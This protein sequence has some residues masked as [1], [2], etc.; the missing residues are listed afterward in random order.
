MVV[1][2]ST[3][4]RISVLLMQIGISDMKHVS[5]I[6]LMCSALF[7]FTVACKKNDK[8]ETREALRVETAVAGTSS[9]SAGRSYSG[10]IEESSGTVLSFKVP[11]TISN[12]LVDAGSRVA[13]GQLIAVLD[14]S[15]LRSNYEMAKATLATA[16]DTYNRMKQLHDA[17][18]I[19]DMKWVE[20]ENALK[21]AQSA[22]NIAKNTLNDTKIFAPFSGVIS[23]KFADAG[24]TAAPA[25]PVVKLVEISP[26]KAKISVPEKDISDFAIGAPGVVVVEAADGLTVDGKISDKGVAADPLSRTYDVKFL[27][28][29]PD[30]KLLPGMLCNVSLKADD[31]VEALVVPINSV[32]LDDKNQSFLWTVNEGKA[33]KT[34]IRLGAYTDNGVIVESGLSD[35]VKY[36]VSGQQKVSEGMKVTSVNM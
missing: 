4:L 8:E 11:G 16:Q 33:H 32:L 7:F 36:I 17:N 21:T 2:A 27:I 18:S 12:I 28:S 30:G 19:T 13:K 22:C 5:A 26:L 23:E 14:D 29:N 6:S 3:F 31:A 25:V 10:V 15:S 9:V 35:G 24:S 1:E 20:V 34:V